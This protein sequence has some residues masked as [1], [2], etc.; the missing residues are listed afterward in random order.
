[1]EKNTTSLVSTGIASGASAVSGVYGYYAQKNLARQQQSNYLKNLAESY[2]LTQQAQRNAASN[3]VVGYR[4]AGLSPALA[5]AGNFSTPAASAPLGSASS[6]HLDTSGIASAFTQG[7][8][9][10]TH[11]KQVKTQ[12]QQADT[13]ARL[14]DSSISSQD[15]QTD[16]L[17]SQKDLVDQQKEALEIENNR[18]TAED[19]TADNTLRLHAKQMY[20]RAVENGDVFQQDVWKAMLDNAETQT[21]NMGTARAMEEVSTVIQKMDSNNTKMYQ[22]IYDRQLSIAMMDNMTWSFVSHMPEQQLKKLQ[23]EIQTIGLQGAMFLSS[24]VLNYG[25]LRLLDYQMD[26]IVAEIGVAEALATKYQAEADKAFQEQFAIYHNDPAAMLQRKDFLALGL[27]TTGRAIDIAADVAPQFFGISSKAKMAGKALEQSAQQFET[28][29]ENIDRRNEEQAEQKK[30]FGVSSEEEKVFD[31]DG[32]LM[33]TK[34]KKFN[35][36]R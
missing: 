25:N 19:A 4:R 36:R 7:V 35:Y 23:T 1:M 33:R 26:K 10:D 12:Q 27:Y 18:K 34:K 28:E 30:Q 14:A 9:A 20:E 31:A 24:A 16:L 8:E 29:Q 22:N 5:S 13:Q 2:E 21:F 17:R 15:A 11:K 32:V 3:N 6:P